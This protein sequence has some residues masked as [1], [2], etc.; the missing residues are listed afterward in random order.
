MKVLATYSI[1]GGVGKTT[2]AVNLADQAARA[3]WRV[4][5]W[6]LDPQGAA[7]FFLRVKPKVKGG[8]SR[9]VGP[10]G[11]LDPHLKATDIAGLHLLPADFTLRHLDVLLDPRGAGRQRLGELL[12]PVADRYDVAV[13]DCPPGISL[14]SE[15]VFGAADALLVPTV[16]STLSARTLEQLHGFLRIWPEAPTILPFL[17]MVDRRRRMHRD[18]SA[19]L[20]AEWPGLL[21]TAIPSS[22]SVERMGLERAPLGAFAPKGVATTAYRDLWT[23]VAERLSTE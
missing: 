17:A 2:S 22:A 1:K 6:D 21:R 5:L 16:P 19:S 3:G 23:E 18:L 4:L 15:S 20:C 7:T 10:K 8:A 13:L 11:V 14:S 12:E 9:L